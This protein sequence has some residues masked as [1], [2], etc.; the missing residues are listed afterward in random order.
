MRSLSPG[1]DTP[2]RTSARN[3]KGPRKSESSAPALGRV[4]AQS[5]ENG[6]T[7]AHSVTLA[8]L[9][10]RLGVSKDFGRRSVIN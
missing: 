9:V 6:K 8:R 3:V 5:V 10:A 1:S 2:V 7:V 4:G